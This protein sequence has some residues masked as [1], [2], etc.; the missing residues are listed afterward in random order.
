[1][2]TTTSSTRERSDFSTDASLSAQVPPTTAPVASRTSTSMASRFS[3]EY[4]HRSIAVRVSSTASGSVSARK[5]DPA[6][7]DAHERGVL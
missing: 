3:T 6:E 5:P 1:M 7:V 4:S 2:A